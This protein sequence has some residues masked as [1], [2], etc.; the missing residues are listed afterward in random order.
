MC[1]LLPW[2]NI[3]LL[4]TT[5]TS[6][7]RNRPQ[8]QPLFYDLNGYHTPT[9]PRAWKRPVLHTLPVGQTS[10][11]VLRLLDNKTRALG[12]HHQ[13]VS[14]IR[15]RYGDFAFVGGIDT[16]AQSLGHQT[17]TSHPEERKPRR[18]ILRTL[19]DF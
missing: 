13:K 8:H 18:K 1:A 12:A 3:L 11:A 7:H 5:A 4:T 14:Y 2:F 9:G 19:I 10:V 16:P 15:N 17:C 6:K